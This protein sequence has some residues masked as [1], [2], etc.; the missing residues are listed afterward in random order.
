MG[1]VDDTICRIDV[2]VTPI[3][4]TPTTSHPIET[5]LSRWPIRTILMSAGYILL[6]LSVFITL[7]VIFYSNFVRLEVSSSVVSTE[8]QTLKMPM[9]GFVQKVRYDAGQSVFAGDVIMHITDRKLESTIAN[10]KIRVEAA[11]RNISRIKQKRHIEEERLKLYQI[12]SRTDR[13]IAEARLSAA[14]EALK[15]ADAQL[16]RMSKLLK[17]G[18][19]TKAQVEKAKQAQAQSESQVREQS[20]ILEKATAMDSVSGQRHYNHKVFAADL[21]LQAL[22]L[23]EAIEL[24]DVD[25]KKLQLLEQRKEDLLIR[26]PFDARIV[27]LYQSEATGVARNEPLILIERSDQ[28]SVTAFLNQAEVMEVGLFDQA[29]V[30]VPALDVRLAAQVVRIDRNSLMLN[31]LA[32]DY[33]WKDEKE[34]SAAVILQLDV[35]EEIRSFVSAG[36]PA[37]V[38]FKRRRSKGPISRIFS[39]SHLPDRLNN[40]LSKDSQLHE[41]EDA[42]GEQI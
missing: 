37:V 27:K 15:S 10:T 1:S 39:G 20:L 36:Q 24:L 28:V 7:G 21:D 8:L 40:N 11:E 32:T 12:V 34:R 18:V 9:D 6:G 26:A 38:I 3:S 14:R 30:F 35:S 29:S 33:T 16:V 13:G 5:P 2:P 31:Q 19:V 42:I 41:M 22:E 4:T 23:V 25:V 17:S